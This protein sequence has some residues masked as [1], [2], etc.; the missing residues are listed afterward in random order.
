MIIKRYFATAR[1]RQRLAGH[2][3]CREGADANCEG[4]LLQTR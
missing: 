2:L 1:C 3:R 4:G